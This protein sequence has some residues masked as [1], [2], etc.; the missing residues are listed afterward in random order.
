MA[1]IKRNKNKFLDKNFFNS[2][3]ENNVLNQK[4]NK[5]GALAI[6]E[7]GKIVLAVIVLVLLI[8]ITIFLLKGK[9]GEVLDSI[10]NMLR[11]GR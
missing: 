4:G 3:F 1:K 9:G 6:E 2:I 7:I 5:K 11:F 10:K 8:F